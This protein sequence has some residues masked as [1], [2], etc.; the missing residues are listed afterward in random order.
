MN[1]IGNKPGANNHPSAEKAIG[2]IAVPYRE[3]VKLEEARVSLYEIFEKEIAQ[4]IAL[5][6]T[7]HNRVTGQ[8]WQVANTKS[9][10][11]PGYLHCSDQ[12]KEGGKIPEDGWYWVKRAEGAWH[13]EQL[14][15]GYHFCGTT[16]VLGPLVEPN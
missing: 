14:S 6:M 13:I 1:A 4:D 3:L 7:I 2:Y 11:E 5:Q 16:K 12:E 9:W 15:E 10:S 8:M